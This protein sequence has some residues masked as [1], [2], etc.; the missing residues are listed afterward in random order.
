MNNTDH[1]STSL[2][3][4]LWVKTIKFFDANPESP[5]PGWKKIQIRDPC[6][7][8]KTD[9]KLNGNKFSLCLSDL[10][11]R[12]VDN[13]FFSDTQFLPLQCC[14]SGPGIRCF[15]DPWFPDLGPGSQTH[16]FESLMTIFWVEKKFYNSL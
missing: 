4:I 15:F 16:T 8:R 12:F 9:S 5:D 3:S 1:I 13:L 6:Q 2:E 14:G 11:H 7:V 10:T